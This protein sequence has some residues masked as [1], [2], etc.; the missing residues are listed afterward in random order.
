MEI[1][2]MVVVY[3]SWKNKF[4]WDNENLFYHFDYDSTKSNSYYSSPKA[5]NVPDTDLSEH[6]YS[7]TLF[8]QN[9]SDRIH[10]YPYF[11]P[12]IWNTNKLTRAFI[13]AI[14]KQ[15]KENISTKSKTM[16]EKNRSMS[17]WF[18][19]ISGFWLNFLKTINLKSNDK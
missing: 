2:S 15:V 19:M 6:I 8:S 17:V 10:Y 5:Y 13:Y 14:L 3:E 7:L 1:L 16:T 4:L 11:M 18:Y 12:I 9:L